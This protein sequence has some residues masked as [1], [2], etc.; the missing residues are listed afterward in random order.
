MAL[1]EAQNIGQ[2]YD[3]KAVLQDISLSIGSGE[4]FALIGPT[5]AGKTTLLRLLDFLETP[6]AGTI[7]FDG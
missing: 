7:Y 6:S 3:G 2:T 1:L 5:G 4:V